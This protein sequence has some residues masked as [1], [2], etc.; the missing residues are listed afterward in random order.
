M[1]QQTDATEYKRLQF[2]ENRLRS[3]GAAYPALREALEQMERV[4]E[5][6]FERIATEGACLYF[7]SKVSAEDLQHLIIHCIFRHIIRP[8]KALPEIWNLA[9]DMHAEYLRTLL[10]PDSF[11]EEEAET[12]RMRIRDALPESTEISDAENIYEGLMEL[13][14]EDLEEL[15]PRFLRDDHRYWYKASAHFEARFPSPQE[16]CGKEA[17]QNAESYPER[18]EAILTKR[19]YIGDDLIPAAKKTNRY[20]LAPGS[21]E[22]KILLRQAGRFDFSRYLRRFASTAEEIRPD[23]DAFDQIPY[24]YG[25]QRYGNLPLIEPLEYSESH[26]VEELVIAVDTSGSCTKSVVERFL[27]EI[28][29]ILMQSEF[30]FQRM[31]VHIIQCDARIQSHT[32]IHSY[33]EW[34]NYCKDLTIKGRGGT[35]FTPVF[36]LVE[37]LQKKG[38]LR[39]LKGLLYFTDGDGVYPEK[40]TPYETAFVFTTRAALANPVPDWITPLC[41]ER[42]RL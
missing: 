24:Y 3:I 11:S 38:E 8:P 7:G 34:R 12:L 14:S 13:F 30:F 31:N 33:E 17:F 10:F 2:P 5:P 35:N 27:G 32:A 39:K 9:C 4:P 40:P 19:W 15:F 21:R 18:L 1:E 16:D 26:K 20:G 22:E 42:S 37:K 23:P 29:H 25:L 28:E 6:S 36:A 41:L